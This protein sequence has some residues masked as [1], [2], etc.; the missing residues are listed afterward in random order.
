MSS[1]LRQCLNGYTVPAVIGIWQMNLKSYTRLTRYV[2][3]R[4]IRGIKART[5]EDGTDE[6][7][8]KIEKLATHLSMTCRKLFDFLRY[9]RYLEISVI[10]TYAAEST[11]HTSISLTLLVNN[12]I[13]V[14]VMAD[15]RVETN[16]ILCEVLST[17]HKVKELE[18][19]RMY[20]N[21]SKRYICHMWSDGGFGHTS[22]RG[23][24]LQS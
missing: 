5:K 23:T 4:H 9:F 10:D 17:M 12:A 6:P 15:Q 7:R 8:K 3:K 20:R 24:W 18:P 13:K 22:K 11:A 16:F 2:E 21:I 14:Y 1:N 19:V